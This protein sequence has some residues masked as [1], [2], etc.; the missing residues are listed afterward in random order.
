MYEFIGDLDVRLESTARVLLRLKKL[1]EPG[2]RRVETPLYTA[3]P[4]RDLS[5]TSREMYQRGY[6]AGIRFAEKA[7]GIGE[8]K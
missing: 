6:A 4:E 8:T 3:P 2:W 1:D 5:I 7:H